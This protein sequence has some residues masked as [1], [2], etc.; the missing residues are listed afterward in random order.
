M[1]S[2]GLRACNNSGSDEIMGSRYLI[3]VFVCL[4][5][6]SIPATSKIF[7][8]GNYTIDTG[9]YGTPHDAGI[10]ATGALQWSWND[11]EKTGIYIINHPL[12]D[13]DMTKLSDGEYMA[14]YVQT[15]LVGTIAA[16]DKLIDPT[17]NSPK[18]GGSDKEWKNLTP[19][20]VDKPYPGCIA[21]SPNHPTFKVYVGA[22]D[23]FNYLTIISSESDEM[24]GLILSEIKI[25]PKKESNAIRLSAI[26]KGLQDRSL[27]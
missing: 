8:L 21:I 7:D 2:L 24:M 3:I 13:S 10:S 16:I 15:G 22:I 17:S 6:A 20:V 23:K 9:A 1:K 4:I 18:F 27:S 14:Y 25:Y 26:Q 5:L 19:V 11:K 12:D